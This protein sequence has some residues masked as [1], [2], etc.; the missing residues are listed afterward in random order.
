MTIHVKLNKSMHKECVFCYMEMDPGDTVIQLACHES[1]QFHEECYNNFI[2]HFEENNTPLL[3][4]LCR[5]PVR[6]DNV[7]KKKILP[8]STMSPADAFGLKVDS[9]F[10]RDE[11]PN[12]LAPM[13]KDGLEMHNM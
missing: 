4:P 3:C 12:V 6:K 13:S 1:H 11:S 2:K 5:A 8:D 7:V 9:N 10:D